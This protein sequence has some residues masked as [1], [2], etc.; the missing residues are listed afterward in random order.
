M[1]R[2][3]LILF[4]CFI[5]ALLLGGTSIFGL[6]EKSLGTSNYQH[7]TAALGRG[8]M[9]MAYLDTLSL[10]NSNYA[11]WPYITQT[12]MNLNLGYKWL[13]TT[14]ANQSVTSTSGNLSGGHLAM[15]IMS[16]KM[17]IGIGLLPTI[18]NDQSIMSDNIG[19]DQTVAEEIKV[20]GN[21]TEASFI[22]SYAFNNH[23][24][25]AA[26]ASYNFGM[27][28]DERSVK[29]G[30]VQQEDIFISFDSKIYGKS[31]A[32]H[33]FYKI[34]EKMLTGLRLK[35]PA[36]LT[37]QRERESYNSLQSSRDEITIPFKVALGANYLFD[38]RLISGIDF[39][40]E[41]WKDGYKIDGDNID[42]FNNSYRISAGIEKMP[43]GRRFV[44]YY[45]K[46][47]YRGGLYF[48]QMN[49]K[50]NNNS[51]YEYGITLG[52]GLPVLKAQNRIDIAFQ[53]GNRGSLSKNYA[54]EDIFKINVSITASNLWFIQEEN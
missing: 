32:L 38:N 24:S 12:I 27:I 42:G 2:K 35:F 9:E 18:S 51:I 30:T 19:I 8:G 23:F 49:V 14:T 31:F 15:P 39:E 28:S 29:Y 11:C 7:S 17:A 3:I 21:L 50:S 43:I 33:S 54:T 47:Y 6:S 16:K 26:V 41:G 13:S 48:S 5:P 1:Q 22:V 34:N 20:S 45:Q 10:N 40:Y 52:L 36:T 37:L 53:Y 44:P 46:M 25:L 4:L